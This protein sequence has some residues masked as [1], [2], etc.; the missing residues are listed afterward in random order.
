MIAAAVV[1]ALSYYTYRTAFYNKPNPNEDI[2]RLP[3]GEQYECE[4]ERMTALIAEM[5]EIPFEEVWIESFDGTRLFGRYYHKRDGAP[6]QIQFHGYHG[7]ALRDFCGGN[8]LARDAG[9][10]TLVVDQ[11]AHGRSGGHTITFGIKERYDCLC[12]ARYASER[13]GADTEIFLSGVSLGAATVLMA[14]EFELPKNVVGI[15]ADSAYSSPEAIV[16]KVCCDKGYPPRLTM[17][18]LKLGALLFGRFRLT[19]CSAANAVKNATVPILLIHG[20][21]DRFVP[22]EMTKEIYAACGDRAICETF[23]EAG[24]GISFIVDT[25]RYA[26]VV[27][28]FTAMCGRAHK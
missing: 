8:K 25:A 16:R 11:R 14:S 21:D 17:P 5:A 7:R 18:F 19:A 9:Q 27:E 23:P 28:R 10:N 24:H 2:Y 4:R 3:H 15:I 22:C 6:M 12:W 13:F 26:S 1:G 20:E